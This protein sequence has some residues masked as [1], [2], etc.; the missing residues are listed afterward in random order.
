MLLSGLLY[1]RRISDNRMTDLPLRDLRMVEEL[2]GKN[3]FQ[4]VMMITTMWDEVDEKTGEAREEVLRARYWRHMLDRTSTMSRFMH[5]RE[6]DFTVIDPLIDAANKRSSRL[7]QMELAAMRRNLPWGSYGPE[8]SSKMEVLVRQHVDLLRRIRNEMKRADGDKMSL[9][10]LHHEHRNLQ[11]E[12]EVAVNE[13]Q[14]LKLPLGDRL[15]NMTDKFIRSNFEVIRISNLKLH[16]PNQLPNDSEDG[17]VVP[18]GSES[19]KKTEAVHSSLLRTEDQDKVGVVPK[20]VR[21]LIN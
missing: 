3:A 12:M 6:S 1:F 2:C 5:T 10:P 4:S 11:V 9:E 21:E 19:T 8:I 15:L 20:E 14:R 7:L 18:T 17:R 16:K 13:M